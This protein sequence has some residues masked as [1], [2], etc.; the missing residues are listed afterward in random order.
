VLCTARPE[1]YERVPDWGGGKRNSTTIALSPL[2]SD[3]TA[4]L[5]SALLSEAV[6]PAETQAV[7]LER[8]GGNPLYAEE[9]VRMLTDLGILV[10][11]GRAWKIAADGFIPVPESVQALI[12]ARLD[13]LSPER[14]ALLQDA[15]V[16]GKVFWSGTL[17]STGEIAEAEVRERLHELGRKELVRPSR[18][19]SIEDQAEYAFW[20]ILIRDVAYGQIPRAARAQKHRAVAEWIERIAGERV[21]DHAELLAHHYEQA[22]DLARASGTSPEKVAEIEGRARRF[23]VMAG[24]RALLLDEAKANPLYSR[25]LELMPVGH[26]DRPAVLEKA[27]RAIWETGDFPGALALFEEAIAGFRERGDTRGLASAMM[28]LAYTQAFGPR[29]DTARYD[30]VLAEVVDLLEPFGPSSELAEA[31]DRTAGR[32]MLQG[33]SRECLEWSDKALSLATQLGLANRIV[34]VLQFRGI[35][36]CELGDLGGLDDMRESVRRGLELGLGFETVTAYGNLSDFVWH[37]EGPAKGL[38]LNRAAEE[39]A[40]RRGLIAP[41]MWE[42]AESTWMLYE[43]G[44]WDEVL[45]AADEVIAWARERQGAQHLVIALTYR[46][47]VLAE[48]GETAA[49]AALA[50]EFLPRAHEIGDPQILMPALGVTALIHRSMAAAEE[51]VALAEELDRT[52]HHRAAWFRTWYLPVALRVALPEKIDLARQLME[53]IDS[54]VAHD[55]HAMLQARAMVAEA[56]GE[57][58]NA[59]GLYNAAAEGWRQF[60][61]VPEQGHS[62]LG[63]GRC[64]VS[65]GRRQEAARPLQEAR[66][67]FQ[68]LGARLAVQE[69]DSWLAQAATLT[70]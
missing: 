35:A 67:I 39:F 4:R 30:A 24:D 21:S 29:G 46:A 10:R 55:Q 23:L 33:R 37:T 56:G 18:T 59:A 45:R 17:A 41:A 8:A 70:S 19:S 32:L 65:L 44:R 25:A 16:V 12:A 40:R 43:L 66:T 1:L 51:A 60:G 9:F 5:V 62:S 6:L 22:L 48:R 57:L 14:K 13:T 20:H 2:S 38:E 27:A 58:Q 50:E 49:A 15:S 52:V 28:G 68:S 3:D 11:E 47:R 34:R 53:G 36:R 54:P 64:L 26:P 69:A 31:Y 42:D 61:N 63:A 7:L